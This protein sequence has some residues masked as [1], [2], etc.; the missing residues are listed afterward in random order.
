MIFAQISCGQIQNTIVLDDKSLLC[1]FLNDPNGFPYDFV[2]QVDSMYPRP[3]IGWSFDGIS[4][5][6]PIVDDSEDD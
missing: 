3:G 2:I 1:L 6:A 5:T 4:F